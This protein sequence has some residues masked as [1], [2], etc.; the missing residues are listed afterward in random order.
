MAM[1]LLFERL[2]WESIHHD[3]EDSPMTDSLLDRPLVPIAD[4]SD[5]EATHA[6][7]VDHVEP[8]TARPVVIHV[9]DTDRQR[10]T[11]AIER[12]ESLAATSGLTVETYLKDGTEITDTLCH[13]AE[14]VDA[15]AIVFCSRGGS[16][17]FD[18]LA[19]G[20]RT[21]LIAKSDY[22]VVMLPTA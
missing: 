2:V 7:L 8:A 18:L 3:S 4:E 5:A 19:G 13:T 17:W 14:E 6:A 12:F 22:P 21:S 11:D 9:V 16:A 10:G 15:S 20:V 1:S